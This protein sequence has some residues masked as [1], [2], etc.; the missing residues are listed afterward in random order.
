MNPPQTRRKRLGPRK[1]IH[2]RV[3]PDLY[4]R[5]KAYRT[6]RGASESAVITAA[7]RRHLDQDSDVERILRRLD[8]GNRRIARLQREIEIQS[9]FLA[10]WARLWFAHTP[11]MPPESMPEAKQY[12]KKR[13]A[14]MI[15][16]LTK[17]LNG[18]KRL[19]VDLL[20]PYSDED[21]GPVPVPGPREETADGDGE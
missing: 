11:Q 12:A 3:P 17:N 20:G 15:Q 18:P 16:F 1:T 19:L 6:L 9:E 7:L 5:F 8:R 10:L 14:E 2:P 13:Y 4:D 21:Q